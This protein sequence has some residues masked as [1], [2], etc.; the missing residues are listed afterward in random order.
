MLDNARRQ[1]ILVLLTV[2][3]GLACTFLMQPALGTDLKGGAQLIYEIPEDSLEALTATESTTVDQIMDQTVA[4]M[5]ERVDPG[6]QRDITVAR[7]G[8][9]GILIEL[10]WY[11]ET[12]ELD[13]IKSRISSLGKLEMRVVATEDFV[14][15]GVQFELA[16]EKKRLEAWLKDGGR[17]LV[18]KDPANIERFNE[19]QIVGPKAYGNLQWYPHIIGPDTENPKTW[20]YAFYRDND[21]ARGITPMGPATVRVFDDTEYNNGLLTEAD[22]QQDEPELLEYVAINMLEDHFRGEDLEPTSVG[23]G[24]AQNGRRAVHYSTKTE[25]KAAYGDWSQKYLKQHSAIILNGAIESA[26]YFQSRIAG[27]GQISGDFSQSEVEELVKVLR[28]GSLKVKPQLLSDRTVG[29]KLGERSKW[30]GQLS[31]LVGGAAVFLFMLWYYRLAGIVA[32]VS[33]GLNLF[34]LW[35]ALLFMQAT[36]TLP[37]LGGIVLTMGMAVD[38]NVLIYERIREESEK[39]KDMIRA[40]RAGFERAMSAILDSNITTF[41]T[42]LVLYNV[43]VGPV[44]GF[45]VTLMVGIVMTVFT[46]F[47]VTRLMF[48]FLIES[49][50][51]ESFHVRRLFAQ[52]KF[53]YLRAAKL[54]VAASLLA[55]IGLIAFASSVPSEISMGIDFKGGANLQMLVKEET[56]AQTIRDRLEADEQFKSDFR[57]F[58]VNTIDDE[59]GDPEL[60]RI[61]NI[62][63][64][65]TDQMRDEI[66]ADRAQWRQR[67]DEAEE[68]EEP[69]P[70]PYQA[71]YLEQMRAIFAGLLANAASSDEQVIEGPRGN[72]YAMID[73]HF[74]KPVIVAAAQARLDENKLPGATVSVRGDGEATQSSDLLVQFTTSKKTQPTNLLG[75]VREAMKGLK[76][77]EGDD[78]LLSNP[79]PE[80]EEIQGRMVGELRN[81]A[82]GALILSW[83]LII[84]YL[85]VRFH[86]YKYGIAAVCA[87][88]HDVL[89]AF[90]VVVAANYLGL[91]HAEI[92]L[93]MIACF[94]TIIGYSVNDTIVIFDRI[95]ENIRHQANSGGTSTF[96]QLINLSVNQTMSRTIL[97]SALT[98]F[99]VLAQLVVNWGT[100]SDLESFA[101]GMFVGMICGTY[102]TIFIAAPVLVWIHD[103]SGG[104]EAMLAEQLAIREAE[105]AK[106][107][108]QKAPTR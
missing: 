92:N 61:F 51:L 32:C 82:I 46:Q 91:V 89:I 75:I 97:T 28:T 76:D 37:G 3:A 36:L 88:M 68:Q 5:L 45:A 14:E 48:H 100:Q 21:R 66:E 59:T 94:L 105:A 53:N 54:T 69:E 103:R 11:N 65:L 81:A 34:L 74:Q 26:P 15:D 55:I 13:L 85:R 43:G 60:S 38:A 23:A 102:S 83:G 42:G 87:L 77:I 29:A 63:L 56:R 44:R 16:E 25:L 9:T 47:F 84:F 33:L 22:L 107:A 2:A 52:P 86:E 96:R 6:G 78:I 104:D 95:R 99:V 20:S 72:G 10:P 17:E 108:E 41:L 4:I 18:L 35:S 31:L 39:G 62:R 8:A 90:G 73:L 79:F 30:R 58:S 12:A 49:N 80:A 24:F 40:V 7:R 19:N 67:R 1:V 71:P 106:K 27:D 98:L 93:N 57:H 64:K 101:F 50:K 70:A